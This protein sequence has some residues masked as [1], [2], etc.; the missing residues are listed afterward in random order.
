MG[1]PQDSYPLI[2]VF[3]RWLEA[4]RLSTAEMMPLRLEGNFAPSPLVPLGPT[5]VSASAEAG[6]TTVRWAGPAL[7]IRRLGIGR[8]PCRADLA[9]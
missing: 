6:G 5:M 8:A 9:A 1:K 4:K 7:V 3:W 2:V